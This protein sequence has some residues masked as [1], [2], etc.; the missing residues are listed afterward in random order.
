MSDTFLSKEEVA[1][2]TGRKYKRLQIEQLRKMGIPFWLNAV[3]APIIARATIEGSREKV[4][5][6]KPKWVPN[7]LKG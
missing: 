5:L 7:V 3:G 1:E 6:P 4:E 2:L